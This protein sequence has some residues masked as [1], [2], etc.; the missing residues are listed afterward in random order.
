MVLSIY[1]FV[2]IIGTLLVPQ[3][4]D[5]IE[6]RFT[7]MISCFGIGFFLFLVGPSQILGFSESL[8][9]MITGL[10]LTACFLAPLAIPALPEMVAATE[11]K[12][13]KIDNITANNLNSALF[14][15]FLGLGQIFGPLFGATSYAKLNFR[16]T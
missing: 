7:L 13:P 5:R 14:N 6:K 10:V 9:L 4:P 1:G 15:T 16:I 3:I 2:Y 12:F 11:A 8:S